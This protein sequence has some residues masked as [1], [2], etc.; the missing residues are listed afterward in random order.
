MSHLQVNQSISASVFEIQKYFIAK[1]TLRNSTEAEDIVQDAYIKAFQSLY[2]LKDYE[3]F[4]PW[5]H[6]IVVNKCKDYLKKKKPDLFTD[7]PAGQ[8]DKEDLDFEST[9]QNETLEY[10]PDDM[11]DRKAMVEI[12]NEIFSELSPEQRLCIILFYREQ[13]SV[14]EIADML[15]ISEGTVKSRLN[16]GRKK[17]KACVEQYEREGLKLYSGMPIVLWALRNHGGEQITIPAGMLPNILS[18]AGAGGTAAITGT[19]GAAGGM[20]SAAGKVAATVSAG[21]KTKVIAGVVAAAVAIGGVTTVAKSVSLHQEQKQAEAAYAELL[22][23]NLYAG[24]MERNYYAYLDLDQDKIPELLISDQGNQM[25]SNYELYRMADGEARKYDY[26]SNYADTFYLV[27]EKILFTSSRAEGTIYTAVTE[28]GIQKNVYTKTYINYNGAQTYTTSGDSMPIYYY[29]KTGDKPEIRMLIT[30]EITETEYNQYSNTADGVITQDGFVKQIEPIA[31]QK[32]ELRGSKEDVAA[33]TAELEHLLKV[34]ELFRA[35]PGDTFVEPNDYESAAAFFGLSYLDDPAFLPEDTDWETGDSDFV[36]YDL[37]SVKAFFRD[38]AGLNRFYGLPE[39]TGTVD[40]EKD[41]YAVYQ[42]DGKLYIMF[43][44]LGEL[45]L[46]SAE[47]ISY[48]ENGDGTATAIF[49]RINDIGRMDRPDR[50]NSKLVVQRNEKNGLQ[51][52]EFVK[53]ME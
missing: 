47:L 33:E 15:Q 14:S 30:E 17:V 21:I 16:Y 11:L 35:E 50:Y 44:G 4:K 3:K 10:Q 12:F 36:V 53:I 49:Q 31:F 8:Q 23:G 22:A 19:A 34:A 29:K 32:N 39:Y 5:L 26:G 2:M 24:D 18:S 7:L 1:Q 45:Y 37:E 20:H 46:D 51:I 40:W 27:N 41:Q 28:R 42:K 38:Q 9:L 43:E 13:H 52:K 6:K 25:W 48:Q